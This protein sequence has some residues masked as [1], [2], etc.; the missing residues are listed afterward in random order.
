M[1]HDYSDHA[2]NERTFLAWVRTGIALVA[3]GFVIEKFNLLAFT[4]ANAKLDEAGRL[5]LERFGGLLGRGAGHAFVAVGILFIV[6]AAIR[7]WRTGRRLND[8]KQ[9]SAGTLIELILSAMLAVLF[10]AI[11]AYFFLVSG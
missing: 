11:S 6:V 7:F 2:A 9:H 10:A 3:F 1:I 8:K 4:M 5:Q